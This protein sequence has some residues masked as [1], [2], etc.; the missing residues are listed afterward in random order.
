MDRDLDKRG[1]ARRL[2]QIVRDDFL[3]ASWC[4]SPYKPHV[5]SSARHQELFQLTVWRQIFNS[6]KKVRQAC[7]K[8][9]LTS[10]KFNEAITYI[11]NL[12][13]RASVDAEDV[14]SKI[15]KTA[16]QEKRKEL[17]ARLAKLKQSL[18]QNLKK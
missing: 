17:T 14:Y 1:D 4:L 11:R 18:L 2:D 15:M 10:S 9:I 8:Y 12:R 5:S 16:P 7:I 3:A 6:D 13:Q